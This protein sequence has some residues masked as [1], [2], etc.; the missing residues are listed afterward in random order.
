MSDNTDKRTATQKIEDL[1]KV[2][3]VLYQATTQIKSAVE[4]LL[5]LQ[6]DMALVKEAL[7]LLNKKTEAIVQVAKSDSGITVESVSSLVTN[8]NV[9]DL[10]EQV[11]GYL[12]NGHLVAADTVASD[13][14][15]VC[16]ELNKDGSIANPRVQF[17][18]NSQDQET[19]NALTGKKVGD[20]IDFGENRFSAKILEIY[21][22][23]EPKAPEAQAPA[24]ETPA[25][26]AQ[27]PAAEAAPSAVAPAQDPLPAESPVQ[28]F[29]PSDLSAAQAPAA[30]AGN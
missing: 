12:A 16:E 26:E 17:R 7:K 1:E 23:T 8:M 6:G 19:A 9:Q 22:V 30:A 18:V 5:P 2:V 11:A 25:A 21:T 10:K 13:S 20:V 4:S 28:T 24:P 27:A 14:Y 15:I 29:V 3:T